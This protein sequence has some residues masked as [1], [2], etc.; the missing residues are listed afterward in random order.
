MLS[1]Q[2]TSSEPDL[3]SEPEKSAISDVISSNA[4]RSTED[5]LV[6]DTKLKIIEIL[7]VSSAILY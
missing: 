2:S 1:K 3:V 5:T 6:M 4:K 7:K